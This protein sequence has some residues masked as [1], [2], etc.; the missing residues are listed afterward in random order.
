MVKFAFRKK[1]ALSFAIIAT[2]VSLTG[3]GSSKQ[4]D[5]SNQEYTEDSL[6]TVDEIF[7]TLVEKNY[8]G[9]CELDLELSLPLFAKDDDG[10]MARDSDHQTLSCE[11]EDSLRNFEVFSSESLLLEYLEENNYCDGVVRVGSNALFD[12]YGSQYYL[13]YFP[14]AKIF[15]NGDLITGRQDCPSS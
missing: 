1:Y 14:N 9:T 11:F 5:S 12:L 6:V 4:E 13:P 2:L 10:V 15:A 3:C 8:S 7:T